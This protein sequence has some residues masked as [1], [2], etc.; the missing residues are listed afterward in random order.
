M[1]DLHRLMAA[2]V[3]GAKT[4]IDIVLKDSPAAPRMAKALQAVLN[5]HQAPFCET[6]AACGP[7]G[8]GNAFC[9]ECYMAYPCPTVRDIQ[10]AL[11]D[12]HL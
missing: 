7:C 2:Y 3:D 8:H 11:R 9:M 4:G 1:S 5:M 6:C 10:E 12:D